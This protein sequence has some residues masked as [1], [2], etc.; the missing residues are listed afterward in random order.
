MVPTAVPASLLQA[1]RTPRLNENEI[2]PRLYPTVGDS[3]RGRPDAWIWTQSLMQDNI[4]ET[5][6]GRT[7]LIEMA[8]QSLIVAIVA[9]SVESRPHTGG[10]SPHSSAVRGVTIGALVP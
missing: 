2:G 6:S 7:S 8:R 4:G 1:Y 5:E 10:I 3:E 9:S